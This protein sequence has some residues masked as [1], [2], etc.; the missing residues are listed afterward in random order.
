[1]NVADWPL[2]LI[3]TD[4]PLWSAFTRFSIV[5]PEHARSPT[6]VEMRWTTAGPC[7]SSCCTNVVT[8][9][10]VVAP[11]TKFCDVVVFVALAFIE[12]VVFAEFATVDWVVEFVAGNVTLGEFAWFDC[13]DWTDEL[14]VLFI[15]PESEPAALPLVE[16]LN[17]LP[18]LGAVEEG[19]SEL[20]VEGLFAAAPVEPI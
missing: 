11:E 16:P 18:V 13:D 14:A 3:V 17:E 4:W 9:A 15:D 2:A 6:C 8:C 12:F 7:V 1:M 19:L 10:S 5:S 20:E